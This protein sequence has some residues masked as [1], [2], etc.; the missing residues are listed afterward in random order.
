M[1]K[2]KS[3]A[4]TKQVSDTHTELMTVV[5]TVGISFI[6]S[7]LIL[8]YTLALIFLISV[9]K[10]IVTY[11]FEYILLLF[12]FIISF[13]VYLLLLLGPVVFVARKRG[14]WRG[15]ITAGLIVVWLIMYFCILL[16]F[17]FM[18]RM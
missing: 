2:Q 6:S 1:R 15:F 4:D 8:G 11:E 16:A 3:S 10:V 5:E 14:M 17:L 12:I 7:I 9:M 13:A 18:F